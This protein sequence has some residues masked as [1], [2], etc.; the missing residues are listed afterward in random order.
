MLRTLELP[1]VRLCALSSNLATTSEPAADRLYKK[2]CQTS[3]LT[4]NFHEKQY[5]SA[6]GLT[7]G[8]FFATFEETRLAT[9]RQQRHRQSRV[10]SRDDV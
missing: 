7:K 6:H 8:N 4:F 1:V 10:G 9:F 3:I 2:Q 5:T